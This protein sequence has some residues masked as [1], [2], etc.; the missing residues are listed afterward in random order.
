MSLGGGIF[1]SQ[2]HNIPGTWTNFVSAERAKGDIG[3]RGTVAV[4]FE[5]EWGEQN[6]VVELSYDDFVR[7]SQKLFGYK[8]SHE[9]MLPIRELFRNATKLLVSRIN[10]GSIA[11]CELGE[12]RYPGTRGNNVKIVV[13]TNVDD[14][15]KKD[16][17][18][19]LDYDL[20]HKQTIKDKDE[21]RDND[22]IV[23]N[24]ETELTLTA[25][26][27]LEGGTNEAVQGESYSLFLDAVSSYGFN[28]LCCPATDK[29]I[30]QVFLEFTKYMR[31][32]L[33]VKFQTVGYKVVDANYEGVVSVE[34]DIST[35]GADKHNLV[36]WTAGAL[37]GCNLNESCT[38][39]TYNGE[40]EIN[41]NYSQIEL[42]EFVTMGK[43]VFHKVGQEFRVLKDINTLVEF[44]D[45]KN[46]EFASNQSI[47]ILDY[48]ANTSAA[49]FGN[50]YSGKRQNTEDS[51]IA[52]WNEEVNM[53]SE[54][55]N[56]GALEDFEPEDVTVEKGES[57]N[58]VIVNIAIILVGAIEKMY[59]NV[60]VA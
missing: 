55:L 15:S 10:G 57:K 60:I 20:V 35:T 49:L 24:K 13:Q 3:I 33:G 37:A 5:F 16:I 29:D 4:P 45:A 47:R 31:D 52:L 18:T 12:A 27:P 50:N 30:K 48:I 40:Y 1:E 17:Y 25:G 36:Y 46:D 32:S 21:I 34:N 26:T 11:T 56:I 39:K 23:F 42:E 43:F 44:T 14:V 59:M 41:T 22:Y 19:Y 9:K 28:V 54:L 38:N 8:Y 53:L 7:E 51:R 58:A 2:N 6:K